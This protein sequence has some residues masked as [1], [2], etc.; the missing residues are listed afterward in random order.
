MRYFTRQGESLSKLYKIY[1]IFHIICWSIQSMEAAG[2]RCRHGLRGATARVG[3]AGAIVDGPRCGWAI[4]V[5]AIVADCRAGGLL[6]VVQT[7]AAGG[8]RLPMHIL[9]AGSSVC[10][11]LRAEDGQ[12][13]MTFRAAG[14]IWQISLV[15]PRSSPSPRKCMTGSQLMRTDRARR[16]M[17][18]SD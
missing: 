8:V 6:R 16:W 3:G 10:E 7:S 5:G 13:V 18:N 17:M 4:G 14:W 12:G 11:L 9:I 15:G 1:V 2:E